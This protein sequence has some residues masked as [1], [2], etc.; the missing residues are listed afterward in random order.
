MIIIINFLLSFSNNVHANMHGIL[1]DD[2]DARARYVFDAL[3]RSYFGLD[4]PAEYNTYY[5]GIMDNV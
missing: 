5:V 4:S 3:F 1:G 2:Q